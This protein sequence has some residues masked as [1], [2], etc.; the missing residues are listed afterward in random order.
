MKRD[1]AMQKGLPIL[2]V[3]R[4]HSCP[5]IIVIYTHSIESIDNFLLGSELVTYISFIS[6]F[7]VCHGSRKPYDIVNHCK[8]LL[9]H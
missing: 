7:I 1:V 8:F 2:G 5:F 6:N 9:R 4:Y 3:F